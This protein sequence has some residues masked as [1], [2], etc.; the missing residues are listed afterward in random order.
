MYQC[1]TIHADISH[2]ASLL[3]ALKCKSSDWFDLG[4]QLEVNYFALKEIEADYSKAKQRMREMLA[5][6]LKGQ[7]GECTKQAIKTALSEID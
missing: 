7:G 5:A 2:L 4:L 1:D 6:W 3:T